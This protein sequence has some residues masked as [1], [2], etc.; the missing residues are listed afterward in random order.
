MKRRIVTSFKELSDPNAI[1]VYEE[2]SDKKTYRSASKF[3]DKD[4]GK[5]KYVK[6]DPASK[7]KSEAAI[8]KELESFYDS[9]GFCW[10]PMKV[11]GEIQA[12]RNGKY[13][14]KSSK[15]RGF[16][17]HLLSIRGLFVGVEVKACGG[18]Q[19]PWQIDQEE[20]IKKK[21]QAFYFLVSSVQELKQF[22]IQH[23]LMPVEKGD[24]W[25]INGGGLRYG[26]Q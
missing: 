14:I 21:G 13:I 5:G 2:V 23:S 20:K 18:Y 12:T 9:L 24:S 3:L 7:G 10:W 8:E 16:P 15:N 11:K 25:V 1:P 22:L 19:S 6:G 4:R 17:D 26:T